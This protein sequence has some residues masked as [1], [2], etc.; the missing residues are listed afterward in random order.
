M[1]DLSKIQFR[2]K[3]LEDILI[4]KLQKPIW[5]QVKGVGLCWDFFPFSTLQCKEAHT[6]KSNETGINL[7]VSVLI[8][9]LIQKAANRY[10]GLEAA[11]RAA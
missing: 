8:V 10:G 4:L 11:F 9:L 7:V 3:K 2:L 1:L 5:E 6:I